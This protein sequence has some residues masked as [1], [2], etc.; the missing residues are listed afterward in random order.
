MNMDFTIMRTG[1]LT[2]PLAVGYTTIPGTAQPQTDF[3][4]ENG[5][6]TFA[7]G[8]ATATISIPIFGNGV[9]NNPSLTFGVELSDYLPQ[10]TFA[11]AG[12]PLAVAVGDINGDGKPDVVLADY[13]SNSVG[14][15]LNTTPP[16]AATPSFAAQQSFAC[17]KGPTDLALS[18]VN[19]DG[20]PDVVVV[21]LL[22]NSVAVLL[23]MANQ[24]AATVTFAA[25]AT[26]LT[27]SRP[28]KVAVSD[29]NGDGKPDIAVANSN[30]TTASL[31]I[32]T[33]PIGASDATFARG[34]ALNIGRLATTIAIADLNGDGKPDI[35]VATLDR[36]AWVFTNTTAPGAATAAFAA[37][38]SFETSLVRPPVEIEVGDLNG[39]GIPDLAFADDVNYA[40]VLANT[41][42][43]PLGLSFGASQTF[44]A[45]NS[46][47]SIA[48]ADVNGD[49]RPDLVLADSGNGDVVVLLNTTKPG[50]TG[51]LFAA[52]KTYP[53]GRGA[54]CGNRRHQQRRLT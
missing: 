34:P 44:D 3:T 36:I 43:T 41:T 33:T 21:D 4:P 49:G 6:A 15:F 26:F 35:V 12:R 29:L 27:G 39:D 48:I 51:P 40:S 45:G 52:P 14:V 1:D 22:D 9:F 16:G 20:K 42:Q 32:N 8:A 2:A 50:S 28:I 31:F 18:D 38:Q 46:P 23:N 37:P 11:A 30:S 47:A 54:G 13:T 7:A 53:T 5:T 19:G 25:P 10:V 17:G 24:G